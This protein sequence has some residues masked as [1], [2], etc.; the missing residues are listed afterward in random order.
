MISNNALSFL[1]SLENVQ[2]SGQT[3]FVQN[4]GDSN[5]QQFQSLQQLESMLRQ[6]PS[7][8]QANQRYNMFQ[9]LF[10]SGFGGNGQQML[11]ELFA[12]KTPEQLE[13]YGKALKQQ[14]MAAQMNPMGAIGG[15]AGALGANKEVGVAG[16]AR[17]TAYSTDL[18][19]GA[20][21]KW[22]YAD[23]RNQI[24]LL[25]AAAAGYAAAGHRDGNFYAKA[26][27]SASVDLV[28]VQTQAKV[29][30]NNFGELDF[31]G[32][33]RVGA[34]AEGFAGVQMGKDGV[35][36]EIGGSAFAGAEARA[37]G[38]WKSNSGATANFGASAVAGIGAEAG[39]KIGFK[40]GKLDFNLK[41]GLALGVGARFNVG[42]SLDFNKIGERIMKMF[43]DPFGSIMDTFNDFAG[44]LKT[45]GSI[46]K[47]VGKGIAKV[48]GKVVDG[49]K[50]VGGKIKDGLKKA[51]NK[52]KNFFKK[53]F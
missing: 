1:R 12:R 24:S 31:Q 25:D 19:F 27:G 44:K 46:A 40:D 2:R 26:G 22:G 8:Q 15:A 38:S 36:A 7:F 13:A 17:G 4:Y 28:R 18:N 39:A 3:G 35:H 16:S 51:G 21:G 20:Q 48:G 6:Q 10:N 34:R 53:L 52:V 33:A 47:K 49:I 29:K 41:L 32:D 37:Q 45:V 30:L 42:F 14:M 23:V 5:V 43:T 50:K 11:Q 9:N